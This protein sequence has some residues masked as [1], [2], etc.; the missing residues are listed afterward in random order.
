MLRLEQPA[1]CA[2]WYVTLKPALL[3]LNVCSDKLLIRFSQID[4]SFD[5]AD[6][7]GKSASEN[8]KYKLNNSFGCVTEDKL[9]NAKPTHQNCADTGRD[10]FVGAHCLP[11][12]HPSGIN[13]LHRLVPAHWTLISAAWRLI[14]AW[15]SLISGDWG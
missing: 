14:S 13:R 3:L 11:I 2:C 15:G 8:S 5:D 9:V 6:D 10:L 12:G 1:E 7:V 4:D